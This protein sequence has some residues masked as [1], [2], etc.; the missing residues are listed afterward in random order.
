MEIRF[1]REELGSVCNSKAALMRRW[2]SERGAVVAQRLSE[3]HALDRL[4]DLKHLPHIEVRRARRRT[5]IA[6]GPDL[7]II[8]REEAA[9]P[10]RLVVLAVQDR[11][12]QD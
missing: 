5:S 2:G 1:A 4:A 9:S 11:K 7:A 8:V 10:A 3:L 12:E 6:A